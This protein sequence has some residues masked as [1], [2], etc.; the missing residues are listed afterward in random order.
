MGVG[1]IE[2]AK[3]EFF[4]LTVSFHY[5]HFSLNQTRVLKSMC[6]SCALHQH[7]ETCWNPLHWW[8]LIHANSCPALQKLCVPYQAQNNPHL[9]ISNL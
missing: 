7:H 8:S 5:E 9:H 2:A 3:T 6:F 1:E 4:T